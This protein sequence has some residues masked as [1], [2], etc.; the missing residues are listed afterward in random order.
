MQRKTTKKT[1][2]Y[3]DT[4]G[5]IPIESSSFILI[6][7]QLHFVFP[8]ASHCA[9]NRASPLLNVSILNLNGINAVKSSF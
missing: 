4:Y 3:L 8:F 6:L 7:T 1:D 2:A 5:L 9:A